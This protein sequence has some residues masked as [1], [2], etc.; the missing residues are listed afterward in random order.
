MKPQAQFQLFLLMFSALSG[1]SLFVL[2]NISTGTLSLQLAWPWLLV[3]LVSAIGI[4][5]ISRDL[6]K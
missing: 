5:V 6:P 4:V 3:L 1:L 2:W